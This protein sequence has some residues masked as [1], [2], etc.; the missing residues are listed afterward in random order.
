MFNLAPFLIIIFYAKKLKIIKIESKNLLTINSIQKTK[1]NG[2]I[3]ELNAHDD[4]KSDGRKK[5]RLIRVCN[6]MV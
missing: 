4:E 1:L 5:Q 6:L 2:K 3:N